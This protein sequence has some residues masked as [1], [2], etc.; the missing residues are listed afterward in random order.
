MGNGNEDSTP[1]EDG[2]LTFLTVYPLENPLLPTPSDKLNTG[3]MRI[4][5]CAGDSLR[6][7]W[8]GYMQ[9]LP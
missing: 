6:S 9:E 2:S 5:H 8:D 1:I 4:Y 3:P 7:Q